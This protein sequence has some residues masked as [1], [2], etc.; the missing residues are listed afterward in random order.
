MVS[1]EGILE[2]ASHWVEF[3]NQVKGIKPRINS[4]WVDING[5]PDQ[6]GVTE[7]V[8]WKDVL[9]GVSPDLEAFK[10]RDPDHFS[11]GGLHQNVEA[12]DNVLEGHPLAERIGGWI[13]DKVDILQFARP[14]SGVFKRARYS[15]D[16][17]PRKRFPNHESCRK[18]SD[19]ISR[20][21]INRVST[22]AFRVWG[23]V[24]VDDPPYLVL[25]LTVEPS[26]PRLCID[27]RFLN[28]WMRDMPFSLDKLADVPRFIYKGSFM[29]KCDDKSGYDHVFLSE[30]SQTYF[31]FSFG[32]LWLVCTTLPF[33]WKISPYIYHTIG[34]AASG[35]LRAKGI[36][37]SLYIDDRLNGELL[38]S[39]GPWSQLPLN[40]SREYRLLAA[41]AA[42]FVVLSILVELGYT[43]GIKK[44]VLS[45]TTALEYL[46]LVVDSEKLSF[47]IPVRKI[48]SFAALREDILACKSWVALKTL[49]RFQGKCISFSLAVPMAKLF[50]REMSSAIAR[51]PANGQVPLNEFLKEE[52]SYWRFLDNWEQYLPWKEEKHYTVSLST[53]A[54]GHGWACVL[55]LPSGD[56]SFR[57][58]WNP[59][60]RELFISSKEMLALVHA[61]KALPQEIRNG[62][63]D[64]Y[65]DSQVMIGAWNAQG[66]KKS[67]QLTRVTK[68]LF[69]ALSSRNIQ[70]NLQYLPSQE[71]QADA[72]SRR[73]S[74][75]DV[76]LSVTA[77]AAV[78]QAFGGSGG[79]SFDLMALDSNAPMGRNG[80]PLPHFTPFLSPCSAG[81]NLFCQDL[82][83]V[84]QMSNPYVFP[85]F[86]LIG[87]VLKFLYGFKIPFTVIIPEFNPPLF[88]WPELM[89]RCPD[90]LCLGE[91]GDMDVL[92]TPSRSGYRPTPCTT[93]MWACRVSR[94]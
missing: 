68:Q 25:P 3:R 66:S 78:D 24:G 13:R 35:F 23:E 4:N 71:N 67:P 34:L 87:P 85:P 77:F 6:E 92:L 52:L 84:S 20:E 90:K 29:T 47:L 14:F 79:H 5:V 28:L 2:Q 48:E 61:I 60:Q 83:S 94:F 26:K 10:L 9:S 72:P 86:G 80:I 43:I 93:S 32:G 38:T 41:R 76:K 21:I 89:A 69:F 8:H 63:L 50:I 59:D 65:V 12:W 82:R 40:R 54:S 55:H 75:L 33:G 73:L 16:L 58:Y 46:G 74:P 81:V 42:L 53:D 19:F 1:S 27:A 56:Q 7:V 31:G 37:C 17:P 57:D 18:F 62:R 45:P 88:W 36:P 91:Q 39:S 51:A 22:G 64:A 44:S 15:S 49:Q 70:L 11:V 30:N